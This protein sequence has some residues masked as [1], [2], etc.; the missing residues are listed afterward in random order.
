MKKI[1]FL[2]SALV[3]FACA[4]KDPGLKTGLPAPPTITKNFTPL[5]CPGIAAWY[6]ASMSGNI[7]DSIITN[8]KDQTGNGHDMVTTD[9]NYPSFHTSGG[10][11]NLPFISIINGTSI[12]NSALTIAQP[13][14]IYY[15]VQQPSWSAGSWIMSLGGSNSAF[16][17]ET[18]QAAGNV[19]SLNASSHYGHEPNAGNST[20]WQ[21][22]TLKF[23]TTAPRIE[24]NNEPYIEPELTYSKGNTGGTG[25]SLCGFRPYY[26]NGTYNV[27][28]V[29]VVS[30][31]VD[32]YYDSC[33][34]AYLMEK[35]AIQKK[36]KVIIYFGDSITWGAEA[37]SNDSS[38]WAS[39]IVKDST[40]DVVNWGYPGSAVDTQGTCTLPAN[41]FLANFYQV[42]LQQR[43][44][45][46]NVI[47][48]SSYGTNDQCSDSSWVHEY[49]SFVQAWIN[50]G[51]PKSNII[52]CTFPAHMAGGTSSLTSYG[53]GYVNAYY[54]TETVAVVTGVKFYDNLSYESSSWSSS[55]MY[56]D[57]IHLLNAG[58]RAYANGL[59]A[60][61][62]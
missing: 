35:F 52:I 20:N 2:F 4:K 59:E 9:F 8:F 24:I 33:M 42:N 46:S 19:L 29:I 48:V 30:G 3:M 44:D 49:E 10:A 39:D 27:E 6:D 37:T 50:A 45:L 18:S 7:T 23:S 32:S 53:L 15:V 54:N 36:K 17:E 51:V 22:L 5:Q 31:S 41:V 13:F 34:K 58:H 40:W 1:F 60:L 61:L 28:S 11:N 43:A 16:V 56:M 62:P 25:M 47:I 14:T 57:G 26:E 21:L 12:F 55:Y 38:S